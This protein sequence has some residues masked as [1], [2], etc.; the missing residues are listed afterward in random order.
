[1]PHNC[2]PLG[3]LKPLGT[4][5]FFCYIPAL[6]RKVAEGTSDRRK[7]QTPTHKT[8]GQHGL[9]L[10]GFGWK[11]EHLPWPTAPLPRFRWG[12]LSS[13]SQCC[14]LLLG[15]GALAGWPPGIME[16]GRVGV[17]VGDLLCQFTA[18]SGPNPVDP[19]L[20][21]LFQSCSFVKKFNSN[22]PTSDSE[23]REATFRFI[24]SRNFL[25]CFYSFQ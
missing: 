2:V 6:P 13:E 8:S 16:E 22:F 4:D 15:A 11:S 19:G 23:Q 12:E 18:G 9:S 21:A 25:F 17:G 14:L 5:L 1:M 10:V 7:A 3:S 24:S 20:A